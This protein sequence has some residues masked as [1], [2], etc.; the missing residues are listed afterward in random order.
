MYGTLNAVRVSLFFILWD[1][2]CNCIAWKWFSFHKL[3]RQ[4]IKMA[5]TQPIMVEK[6]LGL[7]KRLADIAAA[8][9]VITTFLVVIAFYFHLNGVQ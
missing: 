6:E 3:N 2:G 5:D 8:T 4:V 7:N 9:S 1:G